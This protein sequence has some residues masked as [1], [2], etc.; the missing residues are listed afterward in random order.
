M[1]KR[2]IFDAY[3]INNRRDTP[4]MPMVE[5]AP[6]WT[7]TL[8]E[9]HKQGLDPSISPEDI[10]GYFG[11]DPLWYTSIE[12]TGEG[13][14]YPEVNGAPLIYNEMDYEAFLPHIYPE[15]PIE[16]VMP[17]LNKH[18][19]ESRRGEFMFELNLNGFFW[20]PRTLLGIEN[21]LMSFYDEPELS[22]R[23]CRDLLK[24]NIKVVKDFL[25]YASPAFVLLGEDMSYNHGPMIGKNIWDEFLKPYYLEFIKE[26]K[27]LGQTVIYDSD[28]D[29]TNVIPWIIECGFDGI[30]PLERM[31]GVDIVELTKQYPKFKFLGGF[32]KT[33]M[34]NGEAAMRKEFER[35]FPAIKQGCYVPC[36]DHQ[37]PPDVSIENYKIYIELLREYAKKAVEQK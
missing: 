2:E 21:H 7:L 9:W 12:P 36:V 33:V 23:I 32:D 16:K 24:Y 1:T 3:F 34:K 8:D 11:L 30:L 26:M 10:Q 22:E 14:A 15:N 25:K 20:W 31:A 19:E 13:F 17:F 28:G 29:I 37:T 27:S 35:I 5:Y 6:Y 4:R 18:L